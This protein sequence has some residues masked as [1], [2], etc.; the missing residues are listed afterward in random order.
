MR[1]ILLFSML[2]MMALPAFSQKKSE[3]VKRKYRKVER[4][5][6]VQTTVMLWGK[7]MNQ[8]HELLQGVSVVLIGSDLGVHTNT[9]G[10]YLLTGLPT[11]R[12][13]IQASLIGYKTKY[14]DVELQDGMNSLYF[15]LDEEKVKTQPMI[16]TSQKREQQIL[17]VPS[18]V[19][20]FN[21]DFLNL[22]DAT[23][24]EQLADFAPGTS[25]RLS[26]SLHP[27]YTFRGI[28]SDN[29]DINISPR[30]AIFYD[31]MPVN[32]LA[33]ASF[34]LFDMERVEIH[35]GPQPTTFGNGAEIG[36]LSYITKRPDDVAGGYITARYG[37]FGR[38]QVEGA[39]NIPVIQ[40]II[41]ARASGFYDHR[42]GYVVNSFGGNLNGSGK[43]G[44]RFSLRV[45]PGTFTR[46]NLEVNYQKD[47]EPGTAFINP[48][49]PNTYGDTT[50]YAGRASLNAGDSL[51]NRKELFNTIL[52]A[53]YYI[54]EHTYFSSITS[55]AMNSAYELWDGD[56]TASDA[57]NFSKNIR[58]K[59]LTQELRLSFSW[60]SKVNGY[61][62]A[63]FQ[64]ENGDQQ[65]N[66]F[67]NEQQLYP[68]FASPGDAVGSDG[69]PLSVM[70]LPEDSTSG[71]FAGASLLPY[72]KESR[73]LK[74][75]NHSYQG[76]FD[77]TWNATYRLRITG[78]LNYSLGRVRLTNADSLSSGNDSVLGQL[79]NNLPGIIYSPSDTVTKKTT[80]LSFSWRFGFN[81]KF[82]PGTVIYGN[83]ALGKSPKLL[84]FLNDGTSEVI[85]AEK[86]KS[87][88]LGFKGIFGSRLW[89]D[90]AGYY[91]NYDN[92]RTLTIQTDTTGTSGTTS[93]TDAGNATVYGAEAT[94]KYNIIKE[95][96]LFGNYAL[97]K[98]RFESS[99]I[100]GKAQ[101]YAGNRFRLAPEH[102]FSAGLHVRIPVNEGMELFATP[103]YIYKSSFFFDNANSGNLKQPA[104][105]IL[106]LL[107][108]LDFT[109]Q[110]ITLL[111][112]ATNLLDQ[113]YLLYAGQ[114]E[115]FPRITTEVPGPP[116]MIGTKL[117]WNF[118]IKKRP[119]Y[120][121]R[122]RF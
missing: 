9:E 102:S 87:Y 77:A 114:Q 72:H 46:I 40:N 27:S 89:I 19:N 59:Q 38:K 11:G 116:R 92:F 94:L 98:S 3:R 122:K 93:T 68:F 17:D 62:G 78:G 2:L 84:Q 111:V 35:Q 50:I 85:P 55:Y 81:Y 1:R 75:V 16:T 110:N 29:S 56:G 107:A 36:A 63:R 115:N 28:T 104:Y 65:D 13:R 74:L 12:Q 43:E 80:S 8:K 24:T 49:Y 86:I 34:E 109:D 83:Y 120:K 70:S 45:V 95:L 96:G 82:S 76:F 71:S 105:G 73:Y 6:P 37:G 7:V 51:S 53:R 33:S 54:S 101:A 91:Y 32:Q 47:N 25:I 52:H 42:D 69:L 108:G 57:L 26:N 39:V 48:G 44:G 113:H 31:D 14:T 100:N 41:S 15:T 99:T 18:S 10:E 90:F 103:A 79:I 88:E 21:Q 97:T 66:F 61:A 119:Y 64:Y 112:Y 4:V 22:L 106:N 23:Q 60:N 30:I 67:T 117:T 20:V 118:D 121:R 58:V 5:G